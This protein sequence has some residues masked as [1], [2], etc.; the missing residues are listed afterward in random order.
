M[1]T[2]SDTPAAIDITVVAARS[3]VC[4]MRRSTSSRNVRTR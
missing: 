2:A 3:G 4:R 1:D